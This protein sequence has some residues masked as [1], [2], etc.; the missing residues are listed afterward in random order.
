M[1]QTTFNSTNTANTIM[2][3]T[4]LDKVMEI[5]EDKTGEIVDNSL[6]QEEKKQFL[7][8]KE[9][10]SVV[11]RKK[12]IEQVQLNNLRVRAQMLIEAKENTVEWNEKKMEIIRKCKEDPCFF[13]NYLLW[14][15]NP[16]LD[17]S[18]LPFILYPYQ[19]KF[20]KDVVQSIENETDVWIEK[21]RD[22]GFSWLILGILLRWF[23][24]KWWAS[25]LWSYKD[26]YVDDKGNMDSLFEKLRYM[27]DR[28]PKWMK[29]NDLQTNYENISSK[30]LGCSMDWDV[31]QNFWVWGRRKVVFMD[32]FSKWKYTDK[33][34][35]RKS[36]DITNCRIFWGTPEWVDNVYGKVMTNHKDYA[37]LLINKIRLLRNQHP[38]KTNARYELQK[39]ERTSI[40]LAKEVD[41][42]YETSVTWAV[43][44]LFHQMIKIE[45]VPY[46]AN[47]PVYTGWDFGLD[48]LAVV[49]MNVDLRQRQMYIFDAIQRSNWDLISFC[50]LI[51]WRPIYENNW[52]YDDK[53]WEVMDRT[54]LY[55]Y[56]EHFWDPYNIDNRNV[57]S[58]NKTIRWELRR[59]GI[60]VYTTRKS[61]IEERIRETTL[62]LWNIH[63]EKTLYDFI[64][65]IEQS[66][67]PQK[68]DN[69]QA[70]TWWTKPVHNEFSHFR[71]A[72]EYLIDNLI[73]RFP[74]YWVTVSKSITP[75]IQGIL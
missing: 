14:T 48:M 43:Y 50:W 56:T 47:L 40:D 68:P 63:V 51:L 8:Q 54:R 34:A 41:I 18:H 6:S 75:T 53:D 1:N 66:K 42:S 62:E 3:E 38:L 59:V 35:Y 4:T 65:A 72:L 13:F 52:K 10:A 26:T 64:T 16:R 70:T 71:T 11:S 39:V 15:Y 2:E 20:V 30:E 67:Y 31:G 73:T 27:L 7:K 45:D 9:K 69:S 25:L 44:P 55:K 12:Y 58:Q 49:M 36:R 23:L 37:H 29:P 60:E 74:W 5:P 61:T 46:R 32:E 21:S 24:F 57:I 28:L 19:T 17:E 33:D 22:M